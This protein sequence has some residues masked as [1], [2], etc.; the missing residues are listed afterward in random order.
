MV[1][2]GKTTTQAADMLSAPTARPPSRST[3]TAK[4]RTTASATGASASHR[5]PG[6]GR[7]DAAAARAGAGA[8][9]AAFGV[10]SRVDTFAAVSCLEC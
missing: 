2:A 6:T 3:T 9:R 10:R 5:R 1:I 8:N 7:R 4:A